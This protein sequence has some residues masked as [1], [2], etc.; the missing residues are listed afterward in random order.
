MKKLILLLLIMTVTSTF[1][2]GSVPHS[3]TIDENVI[4]EDLE[5]N[6]IDIFALLDKGMHVLVFQMSAT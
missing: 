5:G 3:G 6:T 4:L 2:L 1:A